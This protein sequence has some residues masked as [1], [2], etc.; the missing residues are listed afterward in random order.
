MTRIDA[1]G[2][3]SRKRFLDT[4]GWGFAQFNYDAASDTFTPDGSDANCGYAC[5]TIVAA[6]DY[7]FTAQNGDDVR[8]WHGSEAAGATHQR[9]AVGRQHRTRRR[10]C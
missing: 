3:I 2:M 4:G 5:H 9:S 7:V 1:H 10:Q 8:F 6:K